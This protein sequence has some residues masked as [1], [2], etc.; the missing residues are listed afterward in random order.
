[1]SVFSTLHLALR[2]LQDRLRCRRL[3]LAFVSVVAVFCIVAPFGTAERL[4]P[5]GLTAF[6]ILLHTA[7][8]GLGILG[9]ALISALRPQ[10]GPAALLA[11]T[12]GATALPIAATVAGLRAVFL[13]SPFTMTAVLAILPISA[14]LTLI[15]AINARAM[16]IPLGDA[17][18]LGPRE[19][20][21]PTP[22]APPRPPV[23]P[24][25]AR[26]P[27]APPA[28][29]LPAG[30]LPAPAG[31]PSPRLLER[32]SPERRGALR[33]LSMQ[34]HYV[35]V[36]TD[37]GAELVLLRL[38][39]AIAECAPVEGMQVHRSHWVARRAV[40]AVWRDGDRA[41][42]QLTGG[43]RIPVSRGRVPA[44]REAGWLP[45][46]RDARPDQPAGGIE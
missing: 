15:L 27:V 41:M 8:W 7:C 39:D 32:L 44:L 24:R 16:A 28:L 14:A 6:W 2:E 9:A 3:W 29:T 21:R 38:G 26:P 19:T 10:A 42:L 46:P 45:A 1:M 13:D 20:P 17:G 35:E 30:A 4:S 43:E 40:A 31:A 12:V 18:G 33:R 23:E 36:V 37:R 11:A 34:D 5:L 22:P 25:V